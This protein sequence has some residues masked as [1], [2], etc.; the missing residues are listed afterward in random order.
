MEN[1]IL[2]EKI[3]FEIEKFGQSNIVLNTNHFNLVNFISNFNY[4]ED[5]NCSIVFFKYDRLCKK[6]DVVGKLYSLYSLDLSKRINNTLLSQMELE[7]F[8]L[9]LM[10]LAVYLNDLKFVNTLLKVI[11]RSTLKVSESIERLILECRDRVFIYY[12]RY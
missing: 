4:M 12:E 3:R 7:R 10:F 2:L 9:N 6:I 5:C 1:D 8:L 11:E